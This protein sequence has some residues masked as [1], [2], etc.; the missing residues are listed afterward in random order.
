MPPR[1]R[2]GIRSYDKELGRLPSWASSLFDTLRALP[3]YQRPNILRILKWIH[4]TLAELWDASE[5]EALELT[6]APTPTAP[7]YQDT[8]SKDVI[9][10]DAQSIIS[11]ASA[12]TRPRPSPARSITS[13]SSSSSSSSATPPPWSK[14]RRP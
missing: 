9:E 10:D 12:I 7:Q 2:R 4:N 11:S 6:S 5:E 13:T 1:A 8:W 3:A 14:R